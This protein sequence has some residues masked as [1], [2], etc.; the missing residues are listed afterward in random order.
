METPKIEK[1]IDLG[2]Q[3]M[4]RITASEDGITLDYHEIINNDDGWID[5]YDFTW[6]EVWKV[7][8]EYWQDENH[9]ANMER[10]KKVT[11]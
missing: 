3:Y 1:E 5:E 11:E 10:F 6:D 2:D 9:K 4:G 8:R 7:L